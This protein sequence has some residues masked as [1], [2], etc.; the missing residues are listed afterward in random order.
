MFYPRWLVDPAGG[1]LSPHDY[2]APVEEQTGPSP[3]PPLAPDPVSLSAGLQT[4]GCVAGGFKPSLRR[5]VPPERRPLL[6]ERPFRPTEEVRA[7]MTHAQPPGV[8]GKAR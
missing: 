1:L 4:A 5:A 8:V 6:S 3:G 7:A 2:G